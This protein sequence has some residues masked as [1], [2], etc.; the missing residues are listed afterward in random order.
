MNNIMIWNK[1][2]NKNIHCKIVENS[3]TVLNK[4]ISSNKSNIY[5]NI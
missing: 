1:H 3:I 4:L 2:E 5:L